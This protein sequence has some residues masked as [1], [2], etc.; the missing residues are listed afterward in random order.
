MGISP[1]HGKGKDFT[2]KG[3]ACTYSHNVFNDNKI[4]FSTYR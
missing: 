3:S 2:R 4:I 1:K